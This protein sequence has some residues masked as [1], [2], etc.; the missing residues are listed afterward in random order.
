[1]RASL[2][3]S[4]PKRFAVAHLIFKPL[5]II[6]LLDRYRIQRYRIRRAMCQQTMKLFISHSSKTEKARQL[7]DTIA[8]HLDNQARIDVLLDQDLRPGER[9]RAKL[10]KWLAECDGGVILFS[11]DAVESAWVLKEAQILTW[12][13]AVNERLILIPVLLEPV[14]TKVTKMDDWAPVKIDEIQFVRG[15]NPEELSEE[16]QRTL[17]T[18]IGDEILRQQARL[19]GGPIGDLLGKWIEFLSRDLSRAG[20][21]TLKTA[22]RDLGIP[23]AK[24]FVQDDPDQWARA[25]AYRL[26][27]FGAEPTISDVAQESFEHALDTVRSTVYAFGAERRE[28][29]ARQFF[30]M[31]VNPDAAR[32]VLPI[33]TGRHGPRLICV[34]GILPETGQHYAD[35]ATCGEASRRNLVHWADDTHDGDPMAI[36]RN[37]DEKLQYTYALEGIPMDEWDDQVEAVLD[38]YPWVFVVLYGEGCKPEVVEALSKRYR[39]FTFI[40]MVGKTSR[41]LGQN[42]SINCNVLAPALPAG[43]ERSIVR[44]YREILA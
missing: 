13:K 25:L 3:H 30:P 42:D 37:Y 1:M 6:G 26:L 21:N 11:Q 31:W 19:P 40:L 41:S 34:N 28:R 14:Q 22:A 24:D 16:D 39:C 27:H 43:R 36:V 5:F 44:F 12:R 2:Q 32:D 35:R 10:D 8:Q 15:G 38:D 9:W 18:Q 20:A 7:R 23:D 33:S 4:S 17:A 29:V